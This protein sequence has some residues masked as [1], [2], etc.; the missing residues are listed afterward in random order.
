M[1]IF[2]KITRITYTVQVA[3]LALANQAPL[4]PCHHQRIS[5][6]YQDFSRVR[7]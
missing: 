7:V 2:H 6:Q 5:A 4:L 1:S 3:Q